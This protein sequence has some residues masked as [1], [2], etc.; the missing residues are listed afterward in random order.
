MSFRFGRLGCGKGRRCAV[1]EG[2]V[3]LVRH[4]SWRTPFCSKKCIDTFKAHRK[5]D[6]NRFLIA[7]DQT[8]E[9][10]ARAS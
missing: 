4:C 6:H 7:L 1:S 3:G 5:S 2:N 8:P 9:D 10:R